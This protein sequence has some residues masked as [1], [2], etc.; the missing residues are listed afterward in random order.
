[1]QPLPRV[2]LQSQKPTAVSAGEEHTCELTV[3]GSVLCWGR[4]D[5]QQLGVGGISQAYLPHAVPGIP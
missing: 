4:N 3:A 2:V 1:M 5:A